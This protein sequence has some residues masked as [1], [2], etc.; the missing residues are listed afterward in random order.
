MTKCMSANASMDRWQ[1]ARVG[2]QPGMRFVVV[3]H[4]VHGLGRIEPLLVSCCWIAGGDLTGDGIVLALLR[5]HCSAP[6][7]AAAS[8]AVIPVQE[9]LARLLLDRAVLKF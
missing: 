7:S 4:L 1:S 3:L 9:L 6:P 8:A 2:R 5:A